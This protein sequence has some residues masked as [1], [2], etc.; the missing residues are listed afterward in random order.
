MVSD[1]DRAS[2]RVVHSLKRK[3]C[4][5]H[6][7]SMPRLMYAFASEWMLTTDEFTTL[8]QRAGKAQRSINA[9]KAHNAS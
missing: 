3:A 9:K 8:R 6:T 1:L 5:E 4:G 2:Y 7:V